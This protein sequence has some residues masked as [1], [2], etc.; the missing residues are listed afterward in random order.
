MERRTFLYGMGGV[1]GLVAF[2]GAV[3]LLD[4]EGTQALRPPGGQDEDRCV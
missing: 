2:G 3:K 1:A 4:G